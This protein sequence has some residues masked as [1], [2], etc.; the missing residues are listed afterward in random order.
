MNKV[1]YKD[2]QAEFLKYITLLR[3]KSTANRK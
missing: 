2:S 1:D 3:R